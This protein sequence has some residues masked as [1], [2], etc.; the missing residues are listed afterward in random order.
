[1]AWLLPMTHVLP[2]MPRSTQ[3]TQQELDTMLGSV[4]HLQPNQV[5]ARAAQHTKDG[6]DPVVL[7]SHR[8]QVGL[9]CLF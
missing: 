9:C 8:S 7:C 1:M 6:L 5:P 2:P 3:S 4:P